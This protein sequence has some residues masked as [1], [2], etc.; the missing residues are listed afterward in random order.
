MYACFLQVTCRI[1]LGAHVLVKKIHRTGLRVRARWA[2]V[3]V[4]VHSST[5]VHTDTLM[6][7]GE[8]WVVPLTFQL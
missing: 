5:L 3:F 7:G 4:H 1:I 6:Q 2:F 8:L